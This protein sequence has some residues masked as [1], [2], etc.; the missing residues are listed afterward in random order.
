MSSTDQRPLRSF[1]W[2]AILLILFGVWLRLVNVLEIPMFIDEV[3]HLVRVHDIIA[4]DVFEG[5]VQN[6][7][8]WG[9]VL[10]RF[11]PTGPEAAWLARYYNIL[12]ACISIAGTIALGRLLGTR[13]VGLVAGAIYVVVP[14]ATFH[15]RQAVVEPMMVAFT[16]WSMVISIQLARTRNKQANRILWLTLML[17]AT[18]TIARLVKPT[19]LPFLLLPGV[20][21]ILFA[22]IPTDKSHIPTAIRRVKRLQLKLV[23]WAAAMAAA[24]GAA[25]L[26]YRMAEE[27]FGLVV[28]EGFLLSVE[29]TTLGSDLNQPPLQDDLLV[30]W[31]VVVS[32]M[33]WAVVVGVVLCLLFAIVLRRRWRAALYLLAPAVVF[34]AVPLLADRPTQTGEI[35]T[36]YLT[37]HTSALAVMAALGFGTLFT[38]LQR[39][40]IAMAAASTVMV[41][42]L[43]IPNLYFNLIMITEPQ[44][45]NWVAYDQRVYFESVSS[46]YYF[47]PAAEYLLEQYYASETGRLNILSDVD[48]LRHAQTTIGPRV[49]DMQFLVQQNYDEQREEIAP[50]FVD[51]DPIIV[52]ENPA[53]DDFVRWTPNTSEFHGPEGLLLDRQFSWDTPT[54]IQHAYL[55]TGTEDPLAEEIYIAVGDDPRAYLTDHGGIAPLIEASPA[56]VV[57]VYPPNHGT[58]VADRISKPVQA[59]ALEQYPLTEADI[60]QAVDQTLLRSGQILGLVTVDPPTTDPQ[61]VITSTLLESAYPMA[62]QYWSGLLNYR[63][64]VLE[65]QAPTLDPIDVAFEDVIHLEGASLRRNPVDNTL[66]LQVAWRTDEPVEDNFFTFTHVITENGELVAQRDGIPGD[67]LLPLTG[68]EPGET[69]VDRYAITMP[70]NLPAGRYQVITGIFDPNSGLRLRASA[71]GDFAVIGSFQRGE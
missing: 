35:A 3:K 61:R 57:V 67:G 30:L 70:P 34:M 65:E 47:R 16:T 48:L 8:L 63:L 17:I 1:Y 14:L 29:N 28:G 64:Y 38:F 15:E 60:L 49:G 62:Q 32:Y 42:A 4:G 2:V 46:G 50:W 24:F 6:K 18:L 66:Q 39:S 59:L 52:L 36:R 23:S 68:W 19:M 58:L 5:L 20:A 69:V 56:D 27:Q 25:A 44:E 12:W 31:D 9:Y 33:G 45:A 40:R 53:K 51:G 71:G 41:G 37:M 11:N 13:W 54:S 26:V 7:W 21:L 22:L 43:L 55:V 10:A